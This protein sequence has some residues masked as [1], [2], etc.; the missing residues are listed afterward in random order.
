MGNVTAWY[1]RMHVDNGAVH[2]PRSQPEN[3]PFDLANHGCLVVLLLVPL[4]PEH[5][6]RMNSW[7]PLTR[8]ISGLVRPDHELSSRDE[9]IQMNCSF[10]HRQGD[11]KSGYKPNK[12]Q[13]ERTSWTVSYGT[14]N[15]WV[16]EWQHR[17]H[18]TLEPVHQQPI[19]VRMQMID[20]LQP[21]PDLVSK[22][23][24]CWASN[25]SDFRI[26][27]DN[28]KHRLPRQNGELGDRASNWQSMQLTD[29]DWPILGSHLATKKVESNNKTV[30]CLRW[31]E[32]GRQMDCVRKHTH[33]PSRIRHIQAD[34]NGNIMA[35][36]LAMHWWTKERANMIGMRQATWNDDDTD[37]I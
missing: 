18:P 35:S 29:L 22:M 26:H 8:L 20:M 24:I 11:H 10:S 4:T 1:P 17:I 12:H 30:V 3:W 27:L 13:P 31:P 5:T 19:N 21:H 28:W 23:T 34:H 36:P 32:S 9:N 33:R 25:K 6:V 2:R 15:E 37:T 7:A 14:V 16:S